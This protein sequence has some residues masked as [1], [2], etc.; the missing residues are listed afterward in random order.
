MSRPKHLVT[1]F[2]LILV[3][4][5]AACVKHGPAP[6]AL[7]ECDPAGYIPC[8]QA[9]TFVSLPVTDSNLFLTYSSRWT[10]G[11]SGQSVWDARSLGLGGWSVNAVQRYDEASRL[12]ISGDGSWRL[13][14]GVKLPSG[15]IAVPS[16]DG[17]VAYVFDSAGRHVRTVDGRLGTDL[18]RIS[19]DSAGKLA[20]LDGSANGQ[21][22]HISVKRDSRGVA[23]ALSGI[24][25]GTTT[26]GIDDSGRL[27]SLT[28]PAGN[29][30]RITWNNAGLVE[31]LTD[32]T[33]AV[34]RF[35]YD[36]SH[37]LA[38][39]T[40]PDA[41]VQTF[42]TKA[43]AASFEIR[44]STK[45]E[46]H[47][48]Y[49]AEAISG[50][51]RRTFTARDGTTT[52]ETT[53]SNGAR[54]IELADG[55]R[56]H[57]GAL[58]NPVWRMAAPILAPVVQTRTDGVTTRREIKYNLQP[59]RGLPYLL[60]GSMTT[61]INGQP[62]TQNFDPTQRTSTLT[63]PAER[64]TVLRF[65]E[66][67]RILSYSVH[68]SA[69]VSYAYGAQGRRVIRTVGT[70]KFAHSTRAAYDADSGQLAITRPD[71]TVE[72]VA[73]D[74]RGRAVSRS[75]G[76]GS[77]VVVGYDAAGRRTSVQPAGGLNFTL[78]TS[79]AGR[80]TAFVPPMVGNDGSAELCSYD[81]D[82][83]LRTIS[84]PAKRSIVL[85]YDSSGHVLTST[86]DQGK[87]T[88]S[89]DAHSGHITEASDP[90]G[91]KTNYSFVGVVP[92]VLKWSGPVNGSVS[93]TLD[94]DGRVSR[95]TVN[96]S[97]HLD[98]KYDPAGNLTGVGALS[99]VRDPESGLVT[100]TATGVVETSQ[101]FD[102]NNQ[103]VRVTTTAA[104]TWLLD[105]RYTRDALG[106]IN[107]VEETG[108]EGKRITTE[109]SYDRGGRL[110][111]VRVN[112]RTIESDSYD[113][114]GNRIGVVRRE[115]QLPLR[116]ATID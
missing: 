40:D 29:A 81:E 39:T 28:D 33:D 85:G 18:I 96:G 71:G 109:Y 77:T 25:G 7:E 104:G 13:T 93:L 21:P 30:T 52:I 115:K 3:L 17:S 5:S 49:R 41:V 73:F 113:P 75:A 19:Y 87:R 57:I 90:S 36:E 47:W 60:A 44:A 67:G 62:W 20:G 2:A 27:A 82:G 64:K 110:E 53:D 112:G 11:V 37:R 65:D 92:T 70:G 50:G 42:E 114:P 83:N 68:G 56:F 8:V 101:Q 23:H 26:L 48:S 76:D 55:T 84:G 102:A 22:V 86:F 91:I 103:L 38:T 116:R 34:T 59:Q 45:L 4:A 88:A 105:Q 51:L 1:E 31:T 107:S 69:P 100:H 97:D 9:T 6:L 111:F 63:D 12:L 72:K 32:P 89:Y 99:L 74:K 106:R 15:E 61:V 46:R 98:F 78:G 79:P 35:T 58:P 14:D 108:T 66:S 24:D 95:E 10:S 94:P 80:S 16:F 54:E 43:S